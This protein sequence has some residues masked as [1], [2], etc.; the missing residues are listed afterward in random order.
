VTTAQ[1]VTVLLVDDEDDVRTPLAALV[2]AEG[3]RVF[4]VGS[5]SDALAILSREHV[6][7]LFTDVVMPDQDGIELAEQARHLQ[8]HTQLLFATGYLLRAV[9]ADKLGR[10]LFKPVRSKDVLDAITGLMAGAR[11]PVD[12]PSS[13]APASGD[14]YRGIDTADLE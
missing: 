7:V 6:D 3:F 11:A 1:A 2:R 4:E 10:L 14:A 5:A 12:E 13:N 9:T 8:P